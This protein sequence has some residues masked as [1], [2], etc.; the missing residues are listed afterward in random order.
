MMADVKTGWRFVVRDRREPNAGDRV[1]D[2]L[3]ARVEAWR[4]GLRVADDT[5]LPL[6]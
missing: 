2:V 6:P 4:S 5:P 3:R 1:L